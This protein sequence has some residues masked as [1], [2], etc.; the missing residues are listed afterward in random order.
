MRRLFFWGKEPLI[1]LYS[2][3]KLDELC[4]ALRPAWRACCIADHEWGI[5]F[6]QV[7]HYKVKKL[8]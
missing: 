4:K 5:N 1:V 7:T 8:Q 2:K 6:A 3:D